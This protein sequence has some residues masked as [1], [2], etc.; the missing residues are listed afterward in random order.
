VFATILQGIQRELPGPRRLPLAGGRG[1]REALEALRRDPPRVLIALGRRGLR[2][3]RA[4]GERPF[5]VVVGAVLLRPEDL[6]E[7]MVGLS[8]AP[9][10]AALFAQLRALVP[11]ARRVA[12]V[13]D[14]RRS[15]WLVERA[16]EAA[17]AAG[18]ELEAHA[19]RDLRQAARLY[20]DLLRRAPEDGSL[21]LWLP[22]D[23]TTVDGRVILPLVLREAWRRELP[24]FASNPAYAKRGVLFALYPDNEAMGRRLARLARRC[25]QTGCRHSARLQALGALRKA[26]NLRT[27]SHLGIHV[28]IEQQREFALLFPAP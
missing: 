10:P 26:I 19:A 9:D 27:A 11:R 4:L 3:A 2:A 18:L 14:P 25:V 28:S 7:G 6:G 1:D 21:A 13:Y 23:A 12:V 24:V 16:R 17:A 15:G 8:L 22:P 20:R 5:P